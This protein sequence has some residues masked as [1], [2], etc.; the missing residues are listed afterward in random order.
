MI[1]R[2]RAVVS[3]L[4]PSPSF[5]TLGLGQAGGGGLKLKW[6][7]L[8]VLQIAPVIAADPGTAMGVLINDSQLR[9][10]H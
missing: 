9:T 1:I 7:G 6:L 2:P 4:G 3:G 8:D 10:I 5:V